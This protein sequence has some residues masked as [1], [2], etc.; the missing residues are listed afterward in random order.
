MRFFGVGWSLRVF[1][2]GITD[3][4]GKSAAMFESAHKN[5]LEIEAGGEGCEHI[6]NENGG[7]YATHHARMTPRSLSS[8]SPT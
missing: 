8:D 2:K 1:P 4:W 5:G 7:A 6:W 3:K